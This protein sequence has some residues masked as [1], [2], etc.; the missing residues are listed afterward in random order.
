MPE[1]NPVRELEAAKPHVQ[2]DER[3]AETGLLSEGTAPP[4]DSTLRMS[5]GHRGIDKFEDY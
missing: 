5:S 3:E 4:L 1:V 2:F